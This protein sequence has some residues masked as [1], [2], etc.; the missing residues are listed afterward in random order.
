MVPEPSVDDGEEKPA[1]HK[2]AA[3]ERICGIHGVAVGGTGVAVGGSGVGVGVDVSR[4]SVGVVAGASDTGVVAGAPHPTTNTTH[5][6]PTIP[7]RKNT[8]TFQAPTTT[9]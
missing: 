8:T 4:T 9:P 3:W 2:S 6:N 7:K 1:L 5:H